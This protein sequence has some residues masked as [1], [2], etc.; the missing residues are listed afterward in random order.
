MRKLKTIWV[1]YG[2]K[3]WSGDFEVTPDAW[4]K[5]GSAHVAV[6]SEPLSYDEDTPQQQAERM[7]REAIA[8]K[9]AKP[10]GSG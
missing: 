7:L 4:V 3:S 2:G 9:A 10:A 8:A 5:V 1:E 6:P